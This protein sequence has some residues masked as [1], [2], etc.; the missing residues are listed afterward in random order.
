MPYERVNLGTAAYDVD[1]LPTE[2]PRPVNSECANRLSLE[3]GL[4]WKKEGFVMALHMSFAVI[5]QIGN[6][7]LIVS[8]AT[9]L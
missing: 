3:K 6:K 9:A 7:F 2:L 8:S 1:T 5:L 4:R